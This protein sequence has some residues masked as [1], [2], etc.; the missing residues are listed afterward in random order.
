MLLQLAAHTA[1]PS[2][3]PET[4]KETSLLRPEFLTQRKKIEVDKGHFPNHFS[5][6]LSRETKRGQKKA[7]LLF[8]L[9]EDYL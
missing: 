8:F 6:S 2:L 1:A 3:S 5:L 9:C 7:L 4:L